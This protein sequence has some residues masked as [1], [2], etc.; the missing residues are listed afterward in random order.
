VYAAYESA[1]ANQVVQIKDTAAYF[2]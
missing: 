1:A 2:S